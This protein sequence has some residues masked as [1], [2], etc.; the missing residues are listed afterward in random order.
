MTFALL[1]GAAFG[2]C[3]WRIEVLLKRRLSKDASVKA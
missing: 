2:V 1:I 3:I